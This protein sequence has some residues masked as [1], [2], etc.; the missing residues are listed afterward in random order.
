MNTPNTIPQLSA[1]RVLV[2]DDEERLSRFVG[3]Y[4]EKIGYTVVQ[5]QSAAEARAQLN[6]GRWDLMLADVNMPREN[7]LELIQ[8]LNQEHPDVPVVVMTAYSSQI[9]Q[10][11]ANNLNVA[12]LLTKPF[13]LKDLHQTIRDA[14]GEQA[15]D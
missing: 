3:K 8:W 11:Q 12:R 6:H 5:C 7:G 15:L 14:V 10:S 2:V 13:S 9:I 4:L 1:P